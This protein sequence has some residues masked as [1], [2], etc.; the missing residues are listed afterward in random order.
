MVLE[1][2]DVQPKA[3]QQAGPY[4]L[5][6]SARN[7]EAL[8]ELLRAHLNELQAA[9]S[10]Y[11]IADVCYTASVRRIHHEYRVAIVAEDVAEL[12]TR[13]AAAIAKEDSDGVLFGR[14]S[15]TTPASQN[16][17]VF[18]AP[19]QGSQWLGMAGEL[20][21]RNPVFR[22]AFEQ[23][24]AAILAE[25]GWSLI[26]RVIG[27]DAATYLTQID[28]IQPALFAMSVAL[29]AVWRS[30]GILPSAV[31][32][33]SMGEVAAAHIAGILNLKDAVAVI[34]RRSRLMKTLSSAGSM[35]TVELPLAEVEQLLESVADVSVAASNGP[36]T[37]VISG[38]THAIESLLRDLTARDIYCRQIKVDVAS[39][40]AQVDPILPDLLAELS[41]IR[42]QP[43]DIPL[44]S[45]VTGKYSRAT[46][47]SSP[48][49]T[50]RMD[51]QYWV[52]NLRRSVLF[53][54]AIKRLCEDGKTVFVELSPHPILLPSIE[55][56]ARAIQ[57]RA[58]AVASLRRE[59]P[60]CAT[61]LSGLAA[62]YTAGWPIDWRNLYPNGGR[63]VRLPQYPFQRERC[64]PEPSDLTRTQHALRGQ[65]SPLLGHKFESSLDPKAT[66]WET[67]LRIA[68]LRYLNDHRVLR[69]AVF[70]ASG[71]IDMAL[72]AAREMFPDQVFEVRNAVFASAAYIPEEGAKTFQLALTPDGNGAYSFAIRSRGDQGEAAWPVRSHGIL[73]PFQAEAIPAETISLDAL[74]VR[75]R[76]APR[77]QGSLCQNEPIRVAIW[78]G[79]S[80]GAGS[81][82]WRLRKSLQ[83]AD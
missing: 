74:Q 10:D 21:D 33:H 41:D 35:A 18:V 81:L 67:D 43:A 80:V 25:T 68:T 17:I 82:G 36:H 63:N 13:L 29:A 55:A 66:L 12:E 5:T 62:L 32:G 60:A 31:V 51:A 69:S 28:V 44:L 3:P 16:S 78:A 49:E 53:A 65:A 9:G 76:D 14:E 61:L 20:F 52:E 56:S 64:W 2:T 42:P 8:D 50:T 4:L 48:E 38:D 24:D 19:G 46:G 77:C 27:V 59:K 54:P 72:S 73:Q 39:H 37:T 6:I 26:D 7:S 45:T 83:I 79:V 34:C 15:S 57:P 11:P 75:R 22:K 47:D 71:H 1:E 58:V 23:C 70:P 40:S 30:W